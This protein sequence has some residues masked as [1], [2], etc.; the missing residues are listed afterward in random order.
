LAAQRGVAGHDVV[1]RTFYANFAHYGGEQ[2]RDVKVMGGKDGLPEGSPPFL[3]TSPQ[4]WA[5]LAGGWVRQRWPD[6]SPY[7]RV[8]SQQTFYRPERS[9]RG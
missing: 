9:P 6:P 8:L 3:S 1:K 4:S 7:E 5:G 2:A